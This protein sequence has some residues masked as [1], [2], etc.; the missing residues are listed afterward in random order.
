VKNGEL[1]VVGE[2]AIKERTEGLEGSFTYCTL[3]NAVE[4]DKLLTGETLPSFEAL[5][6]VLFH[7]A[8]TQAFDPSRLSVKDSLGYLGESSAYH[9]WLIYKPDLAFLKSREAALTLSMAEVIAKRKSG[10]R[11]LVF[12]PAKFVSQ[13]MLNDR[14]VP[15]EHAPLPFA[16]YRI[17]RN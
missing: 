3:G 2:K 10:K 5:G 16:L 7:A 9:V 15:V 13:K 4:L 8:T 11:H 14:N 17:E 1:I 6:A 12:A